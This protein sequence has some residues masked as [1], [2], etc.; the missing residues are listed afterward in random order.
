MIEVVETVKVK[1]WGKGQGQFVEI[2]KEDFDPSKHEIFGNEKAPSK[3]TEGS[4]PA[5]IKISDTARKK[6]EAAGLDLSTLVGTGQ[7]GTITHK[8]VDAAIKAKKDGEQMPPPPAPIKKIS[9]EAKK[10]ADDAALDVSTLVGTGPDGE[11][12]VADVEKAIE[13][14]D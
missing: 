10:L 12:T 13:Q 1:A 4:A 5:E 8:D 2:N 14:A 7:D 3:P 6:A 11:I 9:D